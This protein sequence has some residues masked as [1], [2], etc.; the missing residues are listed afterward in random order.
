MLRP[1]GCRRC[2]ESVS[3]LP[4]HR[5]KGCGAIDCRNTPAKAYAIILCRRKTIEEAFG[6]IKMVSCLRKILNKCLERLWV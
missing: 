3:H 6:W 2:A 5:A 4:A 1:P